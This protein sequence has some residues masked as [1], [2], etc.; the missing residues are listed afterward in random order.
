MLDLPSHIQRLINIALN[1]LIHVC[2]IE[3]K[4]AVGKFVSACFIKISFVLSGAQNLV[5]ATQV[6][7]CLRLIQLVVLCEGVPLLL[8]FRRKDDVCRVVL[9]IGN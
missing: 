9:L 6:D 8:L 3:S 4:T 2:G 5:L 7:D 1:E